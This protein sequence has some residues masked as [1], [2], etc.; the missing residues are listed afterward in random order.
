MTRRWIRRGA[1][2]LVGL[3]AVQA[4]FAAD[5]AVDVLGQMEKAMA[6]VRTVKTRFVQ[7]KKMALFNHPLV[8]RGSIWV[9][10]PEHLLWRVDSPMRYALALDGARVRQWDG[11]TGKT[12]AMS[13]DGN[14]VF[15]AVTEQLNAWFGGRYGLLAQD[16]DVEQRAVA[17][18]TFVFVP[19]PAAPSAKML[20]SVTVVFR[21][22]ARYIASIQIDDRSG[23]VTTL[24]FEDTEINVPL[25]PKAW[26]L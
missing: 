15:A 20:K 25:D 9:E 17:P 1:G 16:Y 6:D 4:V 26:E 23:D 7:E 14:P 2:V 18:A 11:E 21:E 19:K 5:P 13:L 24:T 22:D 8:T 12:V 10:P 3:W